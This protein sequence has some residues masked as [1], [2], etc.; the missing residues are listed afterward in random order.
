MPHY[1]TKINDEKLKTK[2]KRKF[3]KNKNKT[4]KHGV[5]R[6]LIGFGRKVSKGRSILSELSQSSYWNF[7]NFIFIII[8][9]ILMTSPLILVP[10]HDSIKNPEYFYEVIIAVQFSFSLSVTLYRMMICKILFNMDCFVSI[11]AFFL[12]YCTLVL[13]MISLSIGSFM[14]FVLYLHYDPP[15]PFTGLIGYLSYYFSFIA[16]WFSIPHEERIKCQIRKQFKVYVTYRLLH[17]LFLRV[18]YDLIE[19]IFKNASSDI[20]WI[21]GF[22][23]EVNVDHSLI[24]STSL[25]TFATETTGYVILLIDFALNIWSAIRI[26]KIHRKIDPESNSV[27]ERT[28]QQLGL[29]ELALIEIIEFIVPIAYLISL[30][31]AFYGPNSSILG[32]YGNG[33]WTFKPITGLDRYILAA[34][35]M[36]F[37]DCCSFVVGC[38]I[39]W[40]FCSINFLTEA[41]QQMKNYW[42]LI[43]LSLAKSLNF[44]RAF[45]IIKSI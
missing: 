13:A 27:K 10:Q 20:Q 8:F 32:N 45:Y 15:L 39:L 34:F 23:L 1:H 40:K 7:M 6:L 5:N 29:L 38:F 19:M 14:V 24:V 9:C 31:I 18:G 17:T 4:W 43:A 44:V 37:I 12:M 25:G 11:R 41:I 35:E 16:I 21:I 42:F 33:Y 30:L 22:G 28:Q 36:F 26:V 2:L 3:K